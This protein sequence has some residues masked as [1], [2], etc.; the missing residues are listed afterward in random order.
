[1]K[2][3]VLTNALIGLFSLVLFDSARALEMGGVY[4]CAAIS[5]FIPKKGIQQPAA[6]DTT[7]SRLPG[8]VIRELEG[9]KRLYQGKSWQQTGHVGSTVRDSFGNIYVVSVPSIG[10]DTNPLAKRNT[11]YKVDGQTGE[12]NVWVNLPLPEESSQINPFGTLGMAIDCETQSL[13]VSS[14]A[15]STPKE[16]LGTIYQ[17]SLKSGEILEQYSSVDSIG[18]GVFNFPEEKRLYYGDAR[19][20]SVYSISLTETGG[21]KRAQNPKYELSLLAIKNGDSTQA[22]KIRFIVDD[23][24]RHTMIVSDTEF[25]YRLQAETN[26]RYR[27]YAFVWSAKVKQ[28]VFDRSS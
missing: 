17:L 3:A 20:S 22:R 12:M 24:Q 8:L 14:V 10:L 2:N 21:F 5:P 1:M 28:W 19:S 15:G 27:D 4:E 25:S 26:R 7:V 16:V 23:Q 13:Y 18:L 11:I 9:K 6:I